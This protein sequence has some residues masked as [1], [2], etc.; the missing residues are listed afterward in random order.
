MAFDI[1][2]FGSN[3]S[4]IKSILGGV[5]DYRYYNK[6]GNT[7]T[8]PGYFPDNLGLEVGDRI[9]VVPQTKTNA[10][11]IYVV[12]SVTNGVVTVTQIDTDGAVDSV[13]GKTGAVVL[14]ASDVHAL[15]DSTVIPVAI[16]Y[17]TMPT[18]DESNVGKIVEFVGATDATYT[19]GY[20]YKCVS[21]GEPL[22]YSWQQ[23]NVQPVYNP[24]PTA[25]TADG[26]YVF[27]ATVSSGV[28][29]YSWV[30]EQ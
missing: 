4:N 21:G 10:D 13:N 14:D 6:D 17:E 22:T 3:S 11:E 18:A 25:P 16:Q 19:N 20:F 24:L 26:V 8:T 28:V 15:P 30:A 29:T 9:R 7:L 23:I 27:K 12:S 5:N 2:R 1:N